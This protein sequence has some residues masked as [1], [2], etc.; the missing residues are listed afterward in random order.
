MC[1]LLGDNRVQGDLR[2]MWSEPFH[3]KAS[4]S[5][6]LEVWCNPGTNN[7]RGGR[8]LIFS[9]IRG[10]ERGHTHHEAML[11]SLHAFHRSVKK[12]KKRKK[13][14]RVW[15][16]TARHDSSLLPTSFPVSS[17]LPL[18]R[19]FPV[20]Y[21]TSCLCCFCAALVFVS[22]LFFYLLHPPSLFM[23]SCFPPPFSLFFFF[24]SSG[25]PSLMN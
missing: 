1:D 7:Q 5:R 13:D 8:L 24:L 25:F 6:F 22:F 20:H 23:T 2:R 3:A 15:I 18:Y 19:F 9:S 17:P 12:K 21:S 10:K 4:T 16:T 11:S 14:T